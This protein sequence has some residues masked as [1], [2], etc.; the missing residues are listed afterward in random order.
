MY[1]DPIGNNFSE[2][3]DTAHKSSLTEKY[4]PLNHS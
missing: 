4:A 3:G 1:L 2:E